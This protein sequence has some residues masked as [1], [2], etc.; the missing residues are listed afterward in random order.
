[1]AIGIKLTVSENSE[2]LVKNH[3][4]IVAFIEDMGVCS[5]GIGI[6]V[7]SLLLILFSMTSII[8]ALT[9][10]LSYAQKLDA[11]VGLGESLRSSRLRDCAVN[12]KSQRRDETLDYFWL[13]YTGHWAQ[14]KP[15]SYLNLG[16]PMD[17]QERHITNR[18]YRD[19]GGAR[20]IQKVQSTAGDDCW[21]LVGFV[22]KLPEV[23]KN[24]LLSSYSDGRSSKRGKRQD[25]FDADI[26]HW[27]VPCRSTVKR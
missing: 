5:L 18:K 23:K 16:N 12:F 7:M 6:T 19:S 25:T 22:P 1:M 20:V 9:I 2:N 24:H 26:N 8:F 3:M 4:K 13:V 11:A 15:V 14:Q 21:N 10:E 27:D 17:V